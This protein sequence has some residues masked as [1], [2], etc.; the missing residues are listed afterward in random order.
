MHS[1]IEFM[2][3]EPVL[4]AGSDNAGKIEHP[5]MSEHLQTHMPSGC[6]N[7]TVNKSSRPETST[8]G[9]LL[10]LTAAWHGHLCSVITCQIPLLFLGHG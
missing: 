5:Q 4:I 6:F 1:F 10:L 3:I 7:L 8:A 2:L 9:S